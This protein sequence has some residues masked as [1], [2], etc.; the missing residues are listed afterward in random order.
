MYDVNEVAKLIGISKVTVYKKL[1]KLKG[2]E[3][4][5]VVKDDKTYVLEDGIEVIKLSLQVNKEVN[6]E[7]E[8]EVASEVISTELIVNNQFI[9]LL[10]EQLIEKDNQLREKDKQIAELIGLNK[11]NQVL[12]KQQ[13]DKEINQLQLEEHFQEVDQKLIDLREKMDKK[14]EIKKGL[15]KFFK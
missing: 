8:D 4:Y 11:N 12:L 10:T 3:P 6:S 2:L 9:N 13:Q 7:V 5:I 14:K 1:K 15:F